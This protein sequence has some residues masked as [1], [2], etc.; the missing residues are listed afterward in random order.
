MTQSLGHRSAP[1]KQPPA[2]PWVRGE[3][4][5]SCRNSYLIGMTEN[6]DSSRRPSDHV[7]GSEIAGALADVMEDQKAKAR[8]RRHAKPPRSRRT[9]PLKVG[10]LAIL[11]L[12][13]LYL[14]FGSPEWLDASG[15][16][17]VSPELAAAGVRMEVYLQ[18]VRVEDFLAREG[19]LPSSLAEAGDAFS[20]VEYERMNDQ[21]YRLSMNAPGGVVTYLSSD[22]LELFLGDAVEVIGGGR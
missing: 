10:M 11:A 5:K 7:P 18:A 1:G 4:G 8:A 13:S 12:V 3:S 15:D 6:D 19:R 20:E 14:W 16:N 9:G 22:P 17:P 2:A 21:G